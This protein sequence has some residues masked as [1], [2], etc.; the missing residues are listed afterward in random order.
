MAN[1][2]GPR[3]ERGKARSSQ[4]AA[5]HWIESGRILPSEQKQAAL[6]RLGLVED[7]K[8]EGL[9]E[10]EVIADLV[11]NRLIRQRIDA[12]FTREFEKAKVAKTL[13]WIGNY[14]STVVEY[15]FRSGLSRDPRND[16][17][18]LRPDKCILVLEG[19][20]ERIHERDLKADEDLPALF[21][22][23]AGEPTE[24]A[25]KLMSALLDKR[26]LEA[27]EQR[28]L[29]AVF[30]DY[31]EKEIDSQKCL[32]EV[33]EY[34]HEIEFASDVQE[35]AAP[36]LET[37]LRYRSSNTREAKDLLETLGRIRR[38]RRPTP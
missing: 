7:F 4:N 16:G 29:K 22:I 27:P 3:T 30:L 5:K 26:A 12:A 2:T 24:I 10:N 32:L 23:Y 36:T 11:F 18:R 25:V 13:N 17:H 28:A 37:L 33:G 31:I 15:F 34:L 1:A 35:P 38:L 9:S 8:P 19:L 6:I 20:R 21:R 14:E